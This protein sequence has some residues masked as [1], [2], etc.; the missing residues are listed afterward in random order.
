MENQLI[1][2]SFSHQGSQGLK[3]KKF[4]KILGWITFGFSIWYILACGFNSGLGMYIYNLLIEDWSLNI[5]GVRNHIQLIIFNTCVSGFGFF[6]AIFFLFSSISFVKF[7]EI[8]RQ[9][10][11]IAFAIAIIYLLLLIVSDAIVIFTLPYESS[12]LFGF[13]I[14][15]LRYFYLTIMFLKIPFFIY[16][17]TQFRK[18]SIRT[19]FK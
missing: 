5:G 9:L 8:G 13:K 19:E 10:L 1:D 16:L 12:I 14:D 7:K 6:L 3:S 15:W 18:K 11:V 17:I 4:I 2:G